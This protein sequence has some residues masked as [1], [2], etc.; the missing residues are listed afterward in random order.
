MS[1]P[2]TSKDTDA[3][4]HHDDAAPPC[5]ELVEGRL[6]EVAGLPVSR[7]LPRRE[8]RTVGAWCFADHFG[9]SAVDVASMDV[10][11]HPHIGLQTVTW[12]V[13]GEVLHRDSL[14]SEQLIQ[15]GQLNL[16]SAGRGVSHSEETPDD[17]FGE[18]HGIQF[19]VAQ[20]DATR[21]ADPAFEHHDHLPQVDLGDGARGTVLLGACSGATS[22]ARIDAEIM[23][24]DLLVEATV[25][26][27]LDPSFEHGIIV[28]EGALTVDGIEIH[29]GSLAYLGV[30]RDELFA[31]AD[32][33]TRAMLIG[34]TPL[35]ADL[36]MWWN[37]VGRTRD[38]VAEAGRD[39]NAGHDRFGTVAS[40]LARIPAPDS[41]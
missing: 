39:W 18:L 41:T 22:P 20:P 28:L 1:G 11:P 8:R 7:V 36:V 38:E 16:M 24:V 19:W 12:L 6:A 35:D 21:F 17:A 25:V 10:G 40:P 32:D 14:G 27:P 2:V 37:F 9:P 29:P 31:S 15:P 13:D 34:G 33:H 23:G 4:Q 3:D 30:G 5:V 26:V